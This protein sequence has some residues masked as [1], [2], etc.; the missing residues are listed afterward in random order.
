VAVHRQQPAWLVVA[1]PVGSVE[2]CNELA[3]EVHEVVCP[4][5]PEPFQAVGLWYDHFSPTGDD[6]VKEGLRR[7]AGLQRP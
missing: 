3:Q 4:L 7:V 6:E 1:A 2:A 5:R